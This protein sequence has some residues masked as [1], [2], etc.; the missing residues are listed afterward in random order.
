MLWG[1]EGK[2]DEKRL[3]PLGLTCWGGS[4][5]KDNLTYHVCNELQR[6]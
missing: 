6:H 1:T 2:I 4:H 3:S 5:F